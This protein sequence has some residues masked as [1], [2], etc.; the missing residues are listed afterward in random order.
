MSFAL[1][2]AVDTM[3][4][5]APHHHDGAPLR[6]IADTTSQSREDGWAKARN[7][8]NKFLTQYK[9]SHPDFVP[10]TAAQCEEVH[11]TLGLLQHYAAYLEDNLVRF[12]TARTYYSSTT[13]HFA[14]RFPDLKVTLERYG[15]DC[16]K[17]IKKHFSMTPDLKRLP[18]EL[19]ESDLIATI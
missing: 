17:D 18:R 7:H 11:I 5:V 1:K 12:N 16:Q 4:V 6:T 10:V 9:T 14:K 8:F 19:S 2:Y 3:E 15:T 13:T